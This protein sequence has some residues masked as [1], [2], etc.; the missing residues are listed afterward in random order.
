MVKELVL[1]LLWLRFDPW[2]RNLFVTQAWPPPHTPT[3]LTFSIKTET[4]QVAGI[5]RFN[6]GKSVVSGVFAEFCNHH[7]GLVDFILI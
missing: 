7:Y 2:P 5:H 6:L 4:P 1:S 3:P